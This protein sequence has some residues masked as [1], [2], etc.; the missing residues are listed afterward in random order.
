MGSWCRSSHECLSAK[1]YPKVNKDVAY[2][3]QSPSTPLW[4]HSHSEII[5]SWMQF[6][7]RMDEMISLEIRS[8]CW[9]TQRLIK[10]RFLQKCWNFHELGT[11]SNTQRCWAALV[12][13]EEAVSIWSREHSVQAEEM[14]CSALCCAEGKR[15]LGLDVWL[16]SLLCP[17]VPPVTNAGEVYD[18]HCPRD[19]VPQQQELHPQ[20]PRCSQLHV[21]TNLCFHFFTLSVPK[22]YFWRVEAEVSSIKVNIEA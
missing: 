2:V 9:E 20:R 8:P 19:G 13:Q 12:P 10:T 7:S 18:W 5:F 16:K 14:S 4:Q 17:A 15:Q 21:S 6:Y 22:I 11:C 3:L 1:W